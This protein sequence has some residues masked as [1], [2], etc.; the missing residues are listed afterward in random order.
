[1]CNRSLV[2]NIATKEFIMCINKKSTHYVGKT[3]IFWTSYRAMEDKNSKNKSCTI[4]YT[5]IEIAVFVK[6]WQIAKSVIVWWISPTKT[7][8]RKRTMVYML[9]TH[10]QMHVI[11]VMFV[12][13]LS[14]SGIIQCRR[15]RHHKINWVEEISLQSSE[16]SSH[17]GRGNIFHWGLHSNCIR[18]GRLQTGCQCS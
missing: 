6:K 16:A 18:L 9:Q 5:W 10:S 2:D 3:V 12:N 17:Y 13:V 4:N 14:A 15:D 7:L 8:K 11:F 1:M